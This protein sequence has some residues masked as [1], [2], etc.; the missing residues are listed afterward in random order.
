MDQGTR[1]LFEITLSETKYRVLA[2]TQ[3]G[4]SVEL[5]EHLGEAD[6]GQIVKISE[7][8]VDNSDKMHVLTVIRSR[9]ISITPRLCHL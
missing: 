1:E 2:S 8:L 6:F 5:I 4:I 9:S 3:N 7:T